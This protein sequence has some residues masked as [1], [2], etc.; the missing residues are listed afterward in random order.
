MQAEH[1]YRRPYWQR[2][3]FGLLMFPIVIAVIVVDVIRVLLNAI[4]E[5]LVNLWHDFKVHAVHLYRFYRYDVLSRNPS[6]YI[7]KPDPD[8]WE[9]Q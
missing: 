3:S 4:V 1:F 7:P 5:T 6:K 8:Y 9:A 2:L